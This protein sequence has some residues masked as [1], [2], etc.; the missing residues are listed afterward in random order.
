MR[1]MN[2]KLVPATSAPLHNFTVPIC[3]WT[4]FD[5]SEE[6]SHQI[7]PFDDLS[8]QR[9]GKFVVGYAVALKVKSQERI[10]AV[11]SEESH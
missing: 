7:L 2:A 9:A 3:S 11:T 6:I 5:N 1:L 8:G 10:H 4:L